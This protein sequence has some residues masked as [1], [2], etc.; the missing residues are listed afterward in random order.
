MDHKDSWWE[1]FKRVMGVTHRQDD[2]GHKT[3]PPPIPADKKKID[4]FIEHQD[5]STRTAEAFAKADAARRLRDAGFLEAAANLE[6]RV[7]FLEDAIAI[8]TREDYPNDSS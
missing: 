2:T 3:P 5:I 8:L 4:K 7:T 1:N 6:R